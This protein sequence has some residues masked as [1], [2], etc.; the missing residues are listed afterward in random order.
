MV[1]RRV[2]GL[3]LVRANADFWSG[4]LRA[5]CTGLIDGAEP[6]AG[7]DPTLA[8]R[9]LLQAVHASWFTGDRR[10]AATAAARLEGV[11]L[12]PDDP[13]SPVR[14]V[15]RT[16]AQLALGREAA[17]LPPMEELIAAVA[18]AVDADPRIA[19]MIGGGAWVA[20]QDETAYDIFAAL[21]A[22]CRGHGR[23]GWLPSALG[24]L[25]EAQM[26]LG[27]LHAAATTMAEATRLAVDTGQHLAVGHFT[28]VSAYLAALAGDD[29][30]CRTL[31]AAALGPAMEPGSPAGSWAEWALSLL[32]LSTGRADAALTRLAALAAGPARHQVPVVRSAPDQ[33]EAA[34]RAGV[35][36]RAAEPLARF[37][38][39]ARWVRQ[40]WADALLLRCRALLAEGGT[41]GGSGSA[42]GADA[43]P[44]VDSVAELY[45]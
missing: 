12:P 24:S 22:Y 34:V 14:G 45:Q 40:P 17:G 3:A 30:H 29:E 6:V 1:A 9:M 20:G 2:A 25:A 10:L 7:R 23:P 8:T 36:E 32:D 18:P 4:D 15:V 42:A 41:G 35:A 11:R 26:F 31:A 5:A 19:I 43:A 27:R 33:V 28:G 13:L 38:E 37:G 16:F 44:D 39:W 21:V